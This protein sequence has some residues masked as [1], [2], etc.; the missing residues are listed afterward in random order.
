M[1]E[2]HEWRSHGIGASDIPGILGISPWS[3]PYSVWSSKVLTYADNGGSEAMRWGHLLEDAIRAEA[4]RRIGVTA[5]GIQQ[6]CEHRRFPWARATVDALYVDDTDSHG[7]LEIK[8]TGDR[9]N[10]VPPHVEAQVQWQL[11]VTNLW[12]AW[13]AALHN[14]RR[15]T[16]WPIQ[17]DPEIGSKMLEIGERFWE[18]YIV[19]GVPP[20]TD[21]K[22]A[23]SEALAA[24]FSS[25]D[26]G[27][28]TEIDSLADIVARLRN[29]RRAVK[30][31]GDE[32]TGYMNKI[33]EA[34]GNAEVGTIDGVPVVT[35]K[36]T[37]TERIDPE[38]VR[39]AHPEIVKEV[40]TVSEYRRFMLKAARND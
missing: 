16:L 28:E 38:L 15:L 2:F 37:Q 27:A 19:T 35:W 11:E 10:E 26:E 39:T 7:C 25:A 17:R 36:K 13:I 24:R 33:K 12:H 8:C 34:L 40:T 31:Y 9:W 1:S 3:S 5:Y 21:G 30:D 4:E 20:A 22:P 18:A 6:R 32:E 23:T 14:G 29:V